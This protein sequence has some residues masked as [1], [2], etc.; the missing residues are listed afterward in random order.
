[1]P[2][3]ISLNEGAHQLRLYSKGPNGVDPLSESILVDSGVRPVP[4][5]SI[6]VRL[7]KAP[8]GPNGK[9]LEVYLYILHSLNVLRKDCGD[10]I[11]V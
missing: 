1:M 7:Q 6:L 3:Q 11:L 8:Q 2:L 5:A 9:P 4:C 10:H